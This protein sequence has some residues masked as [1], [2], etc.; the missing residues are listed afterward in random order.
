MTLRRTSRGGIPGAL[1][2]QSCSP[3]RVTANSWRQTDVPVSRTR[4]RT[5]QAMET[6]GCVFATNVLGFCRFRLRSV[7]VIPIA[8]KALCRHWLVTP[9]PL[10][11]HHAIA[12]PVI[13]VDVCR[14]TGVDG[15]NA[16][17]ARLGAGDAAVA[18]VVIALEGTVVSFT[19]R[20][21]GRRRYWEPDGSRRRPWTS[22]HTPSRCL[23]A[24]LVHAGR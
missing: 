24:P 8:V 20:D 1:G 11:T 19:R 23:P 18:V 17:P 6:R 5:C 9:R 3:P 12:V 16:M 4:D 13:H 14:M 15:D 21:G 2:T 10:L 7:K 22:M